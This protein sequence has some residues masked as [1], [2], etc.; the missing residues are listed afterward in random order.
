MNEEHFAYLGDKY[1]WGAETP[2]GIAQ[3]DRR[4]HLYFLGKTGVGKTTALRN[5]I[6][7]DIDAGLGVGVIDPHGDLAE[8]LL[9]VI[10]PWRTEDVVYFNPADRDFPVGLNVL[11]S[12]PEGQS[13][14]A[15]S[16]IVA[17]LKNIWSSSWGARLE[18]FLY[19]TVAALVECEN[20]TLLGVQRMLTD[21]HYR[22]WVVKQVKDPMVR[23]FWQNEF[24][25]YNSQFVAEAVSPILNKVGQLFMSPLLRNVLGQVRSK[26]DCRFMMDNRRIF[27]ANLSK[28][29]LGEDK[30]HLLG[31]LLVHQF[32]L[33]AL[34]RA[35]VPEHER[36]DFN[37]VVDEFQNFASDSFA[38]IL[39]EA[40]KYRLCLTL[41]HQF[42][43]QLPEKTRDAVLGNV[44][45]IVS[46]RVGSLDAKI[47]EREFGGAYTA[48][49]FTELGNHEVCVKML[50]HGEHQEP[51]RGKTWLPLELHYGRRETI[52]RRSREK[53]GTKR[54]I[55]EGKIKR[56]I[57]LP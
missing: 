10:P 49:Q 48:N 8:E 15:A 30:S 38:G 23:S 28:G 14:L 1:G 16:G 20:T 22:R 43:N 25:S 35:D 54:N 27:I 26:I 7:Q 57:R 52:I 19:A 44:G 11:H 56:W 3:A 41:S 42:M 17:A 55:I 33:A 40:R 45:A 34:S 51:F 24:D 46:F 6:A 12:F 39:S 18:Y 9:N 47:L 21:K 2:F 31:A 53:Y 29:K 36:N 50:A 32:Q 13:H 4:N 5:L 37:L